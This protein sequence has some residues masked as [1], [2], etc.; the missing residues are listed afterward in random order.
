MEEKEKPVRADDGTDR[1][2][3]LKEVAERLGCSQQFVGRLIKGGL[4][5]AL[6]F[7]R[8]KR[9]PKSVF[10][11]FIASNVGNDLKELAEARGV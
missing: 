3:G 8:N 11:A 5:G 4:L 6:R 2:M 7:G 9:V 10:N 1:L